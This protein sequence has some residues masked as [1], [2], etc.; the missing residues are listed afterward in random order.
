[1]GF[2]AVVIEVG[3]VGFSSLNYRSKC[4]AIYTCS[5]DGKRVGR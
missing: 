3:G 2:I 4:K 1:V 5:N